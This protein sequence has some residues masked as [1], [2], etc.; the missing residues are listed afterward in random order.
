MATCLAGAVRWFVVRVFRGLLS[1]F[2]CAS[3][4]FGF[5]CRMWDSIVLIPGY[6]FFIYL[7]SQRQNC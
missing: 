3:F 1:V 7:I 4:P 6:C 2:L 5:K